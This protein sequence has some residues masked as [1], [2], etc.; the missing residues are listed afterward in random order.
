MEENT[1]EGNVHSI[2]STLEDERM[3]LNRVNIDL[4]Q[5]LLLHPQMNNNDG[6]A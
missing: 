6:A 2:L 5:K 1:T 3:E 4:Y